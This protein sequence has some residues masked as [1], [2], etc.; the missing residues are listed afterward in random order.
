M[1][2]KWFRPENVKSIPE[3]LEIQVKQRGEST[4]LIYFGKRI[5]YKILW[6]LSS[7]V[8]SFIYRS[9]SPTK[10]HI[11]IFMPNI[12][13]FAF[14]YYG[15]LIARKIA[16]PINFL[17]IANELRSKPTEQIKITSEVSDQLK[18]SQPSIIFV[19]DFLYPILK[20]ITMPWTPKIVV[21][22]PAD[23]L[24]FPLNLLYG[25]K[26]KKEGK[27]TGPFTD[28][29]LTFKED[30]FQST[31]LSSKDLNHPNL[32]SI[33][34]LQ[35][36][37]GTTG[38]PK[39]VMLTHKNIVSN[40]LQGREHLGDL[41][42]DGNE[43]TLGALPFFHIYGLTVCLNTALLSLG[44][45]VVLM[46]SFNPKDAIKIINKYKVTIFP[47]VNRMYKALTDQEE[48]MKKSNL[49]SLKLCISG[50]GPIDKSI[51]DKFRKLTGTAIVE[52][53]GLSETSPIVS[54]TTPKDIDKPRASKGNLIGTILP[55]TEIQ[56]IDDDKKNLPAGEIGTILIHGPQVM[57]G[58]YAKP[59]DTS[60]VLS[61]GW[62]N[63]GDIGYVD[64][65]GRL[66]F[67]DRAKDIIKRR[68]E[69]IY[70]SHIEKILANCPLVDEIFVIG[71]PDTKDGEVPIA[72]IVLKK[73]LGTKTEPQ[74]KTEIMTYIKS[75]ATSLQIPSNILFF[76]SFD[77]FKNPIGKI[78]KR[79]L[80]EDVLKQL[81]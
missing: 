46:P 31:F 59:E 28:D 32:S 78:L 29:V 51:C 25:F 24:P 9:A 19:A 57:H 22:S 75:S 55:E 47:G 3:M 66:Y 52:G 70:A 49:S 69:N 26:A 38:S 23:F 76:K 65:Q 33:A 62:F 40:V 21:V 17:S 53:Y 74:T 7:R 79:K 8:A 56:I 81:S 77:E 48:L 61:E 12:P 30:V 44:G 45:S 64:D 6:D 73:E 42:L 13:Q 50:A 4:A 41:L 5:S 27:Y 39:G 67:V 34:Q 35:Y 10:K 71:I 18:D 80:K 68:G 1:E 63:S 60:A 37:G 2:Y 20:Q 15:T 11:A 36:T 54:A 14:C 43:V 16:V 58:Y 72:C